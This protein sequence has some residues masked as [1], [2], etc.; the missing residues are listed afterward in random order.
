MVKDILLSYF[1]TTL[2]EQ[3]FTIRLGTLL[4]FTQEEHKKSLMLYQKVIIQ[5]QEDDLAG[6]LVGHVEMKQQPEKEKFL[7]RIK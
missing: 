1:D 5:V 4:D 7:I 3:K 6:Y 2:D